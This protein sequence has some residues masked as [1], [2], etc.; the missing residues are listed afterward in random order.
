MLAK[1]IGA[2]AAVAIFFVYFSV[3]GHWPVLEALLGFVLAL[4][5]GLFAWWETDRRMRG[6]GG[7]P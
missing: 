4:A 6:R 5:G 1:V 7:T 3:V 2:I